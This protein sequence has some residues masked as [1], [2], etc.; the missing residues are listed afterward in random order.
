MAQIGEV[1]ESSIIPS[2]MQPETEITFIDENYYIINQGGEVVEE[3]KIVLP[4]YIQTKINIAKIEGTYYTAYQGTNPKPVA[5]LK[6]SYA[7]DGF[8]LRLDYPE[9]AEPEVEKVISPNERLRSGPSQNDT[10]LYKWGAH[11]NQIW[12]IGNSRTAR[13]GYGRATNFT[14]K[15][16]QRNHILTKGDVATSLAYDN[17]DFGTVLHVNGPK[18]GGGIVFVDFIKRDVGGMPDAVLDIWKTGVEEF[19]YTWSKSLSINNIQ[20]VHD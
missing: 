6:V 17:C 11:E 5:G 8:I 4:N 9:N 10:L 12:R 13:F 1:V 2:Q 20:Y 16:G 3:T 19:G 15:I 7:D 14:D 18:K